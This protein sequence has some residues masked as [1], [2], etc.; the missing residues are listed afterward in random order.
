MCLAFFRRSVDFGDVIAAS[1]TTAV[2]HPSFSLARASNDL[3]ERLMALGTEAADV[4][5]EN[6]T[7]SQGM[8]PLKSV[9][10]DS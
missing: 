2:G 10:R 1:S 8:S 5:E 4:T 6:A 3:Q 9:I 7:Q